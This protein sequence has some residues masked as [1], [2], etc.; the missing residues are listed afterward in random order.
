MTKKY[1]IMIVEDNDTNR[2]MFRKLIER[3]SEL[4]VEDYAHG[5]DA[6]ERLV[7]L[8]EEK[9]INYYSMILSDIDMPL[10]NG[11][12]FAKRAH[13]LAPETPLVLMTGGNHSD[14]PGNVKKVLEKP[15]DLRELHYTLE[16]YMRK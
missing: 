11:K 10:M 15:F 12:E 9:K 4:E 14:I 2:I 8:N 5:L 13:L 3:K 6:Y 16:K 1:R 7:R